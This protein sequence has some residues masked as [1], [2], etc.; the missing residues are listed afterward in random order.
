MG[1]VSHIAWL[2]NWNTQHAMRNP[3]AVQK[4]FR[5]VRCAGLTGPIQKVQSDSRF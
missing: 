5:E 2:R 3:E 4:L 1:C